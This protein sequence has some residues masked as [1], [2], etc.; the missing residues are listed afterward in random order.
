MCLSAADKQLLIRFGI[1]SSCY[2]SM[3]ISLSN[4]ESTDSNVLRIQWHYKAVFLLLLLFLKDDFFVTQGTSL[5][6]RVM[7]EALI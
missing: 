6:R 3:H 4:T 5:L 7:L 2:S 1:Q